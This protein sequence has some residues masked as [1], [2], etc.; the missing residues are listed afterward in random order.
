MAQAI[1]EHLDRMALLE[2]A[3]WRNGAYR[4]HLLTEPGDIELV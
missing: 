4:R 2:V 3:D 1:D